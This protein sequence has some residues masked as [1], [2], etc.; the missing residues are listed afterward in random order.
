MRVI[1]WVLLSLLNILP[2]AFARDLENKSE[3]LFVNQIAIDTKDSKVLYV[4]TSFSVGIL[5]TVDGGKS[6][7]EINQGLRSMSFTQIA[8][9]PIDSSHLYL[10][11][12]CAGF[13]VSW[14][15]GETWVE[16]N[17]RL[18]NTEIGKLVFNPLE[19]DSA[20]AVT[21]QGVYKTEGGGKKWIPFNQ[22]D[23]FTKGFE[24]I[25]LIPIPIRPATFFLGSK[26]GLFTRHEGDS[27]WVSAGEPFVGKQVSALARDPRAGRL[28]A[29]VFRRG[30][31]E[32]LLE[33][34]LFAS[35]D[36]GKKW[37]RL[38]EGLEK[39]WIREIAIDVSAPG[40]LYLGTNGRGILKSVDGGRKWKE[41]N[42]GLSD[43]NLDIRSLVIDPHDPM[44]LY[45]GSYGHWVFQSQDAGNTWRPL[46]LGPH[47]T[48]AEIMD[49]LSH[50]SEM[51]RKKSAG[52]DFP[53]VVFKKCNK[54]HGWTDP[55]INMAS[56]TLWMVPA[57][58]R[59]WEMTVKRMSDGAGLTPAEEIT[60]TDFLQSYTDR[61]AG[62]P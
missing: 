3:G 26:E 17:D 51:V 19:K 12:G 52:R 13:Y 59:N 7:R 25:S 34:G 57:N 15:G 49:H 6:W 20:Y 9:D 24:F 47:Q 37:S 21:I 50:E 29:A 56:H 39:D 60:I 22:G 54:C 1:L 28:Y 42:T 53:P 23:T 16:R 41:M 14:D 4:A 31:L 40:T 38:G 46:P 48:S 44:I 36:E 55:L 2:N 35:D 27:G 61:I 45:A 43:P 33:G 18:Q 11:D 8:V 32:T 30:M 62:T 58:R 10:A 5:K